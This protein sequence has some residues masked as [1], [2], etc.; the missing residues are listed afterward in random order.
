MLCPFCKT[1]NKVLKTADHVIC[2]KCNNSVNIQKDKPGPPNNPFN[3]YGQVK[4]NNP[5]RYNNYMPPVN[6]PLRYSDFFTPTPY[7]PPQMNPYVPN[8]PIYPNMN[9]YQPPVYQHPFYPMNKQTLDAYAYSKAKYEVLKNSM[10]KDY[11]SK[12]DSLTSKIKNLDKSL[13]DELYKYQSRSPV[14]L[15]G[16]LPDKYQ[17]SPRLRSPG[18]NKSEAI[19]KTMFN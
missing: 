7:G 5:F 10:E 16:N 2:Y 19:Y 11:K 3:P 12:N 4:E 18:L 6:K 1:E 14:H 9:P 17:S 15:R 13:N 8:Y